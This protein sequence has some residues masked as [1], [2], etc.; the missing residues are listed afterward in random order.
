[1]GERTLGLL[2]PGGMGASVGA[3]SVSGGARTLWASEGRS[4]ATRQRADRAGLIDVE[5]LRNLVDSSDV[6]LCICPPDAALD[7][8]RSVAKMAFDGI[9]V[10]ANAVAPETARQAERILQQAGAR[11]V[12]GGIIGPPAHAPGK[13]RMY[14][15]GEDAQA[16]ADCFSKTALEAITLSGKSGTASALKMAYAAYTKGTSALLMLVR[17]LARREEVGDALVEEWAK[18]I[19]D[20]PARSERAATTTAP[21]AWR[22]VGEMKEVATAM[23]GAGLPSGFHRAA[24]ELYQRLEGF[25]D[26]PETP[27]LDSVLDRI[28]A[29]D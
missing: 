8:A 24:A 7:V 17:S 21:K 26:V 18:S 6:I 14:L 16:V 9:Y 10:E 4:A 3:A 13:T 29:H 12:D 1:M 2:H 23:E 28:L 11:F 20:L 27:H 22:F 25:K 19:P 5:T 15:A